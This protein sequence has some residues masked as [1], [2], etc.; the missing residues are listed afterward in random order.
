VTGGQPVTISYSITNASGRPI[1]AATTE[2]LVLI[3]ADLDLSGVVL[4]DISQNIAAGA[5]VDGSLQSDLFGAE[6]GTQSIGIMTGTRITGG[7]TDSQV[8]AKSTVTVQA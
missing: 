5:T 1:E 7:T 4:A 2:I 6:I 8:I 3:G